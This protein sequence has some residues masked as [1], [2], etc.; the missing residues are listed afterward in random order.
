MSPRSPETGP[1]PAKGEPPAP[2][3]PTPRRRLLASL[4]RHPLRALAACAALALLGAAAAWGWNAWAAGRSLRAARAALDRRDFPAARAHLDDCL[5]RRPDDPA[6]HLLAAQAARRAGLCAEAEG[7]LD[8]CQRLGGVTDETRLEWDLLHAQQGDL[9]GAE[10][11]LRAT[12]TPEHPQARLVLEA[13]AQGY[14]KAERLGDALEALGLWLARWPDDPQAL[15]WRGWVA[16]HVGNPRDAA[17]DYRRALESDPGHFEARL[18]LARVL[19]RGHQAREAAEHFEPLRQSRPDEPDVL[20][21]LAGCRAELG[22]ADGAARL[23]DGVLAQHPHHA[24]ALTERGKLALEAGQAEQAERWLREAVARAP[25]DREALYRLVQCLR[26][27]G[28]GAEADRLDRELAG[29]TKDLRRLEEII[30]AVFKKPQDADL[31]CEAG[32]IALRRG[33]EAEG[34]RWLD[35]ALRLEPRHR[36]AHEALADYF[37]GKGEAEEAARHRQAAGQLK[38]PTR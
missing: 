28:K 32:R 4:R 31:R 34:L 8:R 36:G 13:L 21:G 9:A 19:L 15:A 29:L 14:L 27:Q 25:D 5:R 6:L 35:G 10:R 2:P 12:I 38:G 24:R 16:E 37:E 7:H 1:V 26:R 20:L 22:D 3:G 17:A 33:R 11:R 23:L 18:G 30:R